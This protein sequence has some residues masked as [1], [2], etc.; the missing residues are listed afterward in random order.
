MKHPDTAHTSVQQTERTLG[1]GALYATAIGM[2]IGTGVITMTG[3]AIANTGHAVIFAYLLA[4]LLMA[5]SIIPYSYLGGTIRLEGGSYTQMALIAPKYIT[6]I[7]VYIML[8]QVVII[9]LYGVS[10]ADYL[11]ELVPGIN[12]LA[13]EIIFVS[14]M[15]F[16]NFLG[17]KTYAA[18]QVIMVVIMAAALTLYAVFGFAKVDIPAYF[19]APDFFYDGTGGFLVAVALLSFATDGAK[20]LINFSAMAKNPTKDIPQIMLRSTLGVGAVYAIIGVVSA[21]VL[22]VVQVAG[23]PLS[24]VAFEIFPYWL[25]I[26]FMCAGALFAIATTLNAS[27]GGVLDPMIQQA[28]DGW[29]PKIFMKRHSRFHTPYLMLLLCYGVSLVPLIL[30]LNLD[31]LSNCT[32]ILMRAQTALV[33]FYTIRLPKVLPEVWACSP[34]HVS[35]RRLKIVCIATGCIAVM[36]MVVLLIDCEFIE[37]LGNCLLLG[38][39]MLLAALRNKKAVINVIYEKI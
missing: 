25:Y 2:V 14:L 31:T 36:Q 21:G 7:S 9:A 4:A 33:C 28:N 23:Q 37:L 16:L 17:V 5:V 24:K 20:N 27:I 30:G 6:G 35:D 3:T 1:R 19:T 15:F 8:F 26:F 22:P 10:F 29:L 39:S 34:M 13:V 12:R 11:L 38:G 32:V 18:A